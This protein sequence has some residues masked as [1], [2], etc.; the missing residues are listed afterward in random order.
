MHTKPLIGLLA[1]AA[2]GV[3]AC[4]SSGSNDASN[5]AAPAAAA[6]TAPAPASPGSTVAVKV[7]DNAGAKILVGADGKTLYGFTNDIDAKSTCYSA[8]AEAWPPVIVDAQ[9]T[10]GPGLDTGVFSTVT[11][12]DGTLQLAAG[13][14][15][16]YEYSGDATSGDTNGQASGDVWFI[17]GSDAKLVKGGAGTATGPTTT[18]AYGQSAPPSTTAPAAKAAAPTTAAAST[19]ATTAAPAAATIMVAKTSLGNVLA[20]AQGRTLYAFTKDVDGTPTCTDACAKAW[21][22]ATVSGDA[23]AGPGITA[24]VTVIDAPG[25]GKMMKVGKWPV[26]RFAGDAAPGDTNGQGS[27]GSWF[28]IGADGNLVKS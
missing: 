6:A 11:R 5:A 18:P 26:Y 21:P 28:V 20:D 4:G 25:G 17:V 1:I 3:A 16:L 23:S 8:C 22:P 14:W 2:V 10:V 7:A 13:K 15:P 19:P 12:D 27:G 9:W 24:A